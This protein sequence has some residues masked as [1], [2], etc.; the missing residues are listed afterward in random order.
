METIEIVNFILLT[1]FFSAILL[2]VSFVNSTNS[3]KE[4]FENITQKDKIPTCSEAGAAINQVMRYIASDITGDG[5]IVL[6]N[7]KE[8]FFEVD[9]NK[10]GIK[11]S[12]EPD[13]L[14]KDW[15]NPLNCGS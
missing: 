11:K 6:N 2:Y 8:T 5:M 4:M 14:Y 13:T 10:I 3:T 12:L 7:F 9:K 15:I 1:V